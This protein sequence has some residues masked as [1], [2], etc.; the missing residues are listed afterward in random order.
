VSA[1]IHSGNLDQECAKLLADKR[2]VE[3]FHDSPNHSFTGSVPYSAET[4]FLFDQSLTIVNLATQTPRRFINLVS[5]LSPAIQDIF[6][7]YYLLGRTY[8]QIGTLLF[9]NKTVA[10]SQAIVKRGNYFGLRALCAVIKF[11]GKPSEAQA[12]RHPRLAEAYEAMLTFQARIEV[13]WSSVKTPTDLGDFEIA[14]NGH[15]AEFFAPS[16]SVLG[17]SSSLGFNQ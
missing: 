6:F 8:K 11:K 13:A 17:P 12:Q 9:P 2:A 7:Q 14:P 15:L 4:N 3:L 16:W 1:Q 10:A 5:Y